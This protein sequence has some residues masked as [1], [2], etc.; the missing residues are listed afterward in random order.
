ML[1]HK[2]SHIRTIVEDALISEE[3]TP[4]LVRLVAQDIDRMSHMRVDT[5]SENEPAVK[6]SHSPTGLRRDVSRRCKGCS[7]P[8]GVPSSIDRRPD[9]R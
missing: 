3:A 8:H 1:C 9:A 7:G 5:K 4:G 2:C 6:A